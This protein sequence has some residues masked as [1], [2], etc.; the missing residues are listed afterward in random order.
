MYI[1]MGWGFA[2]GFGLGTYKSP[3]DIK[4]N[5]V[6]GIVGVTLT[7][8]WVLNN[9]VTPVIKTAAADLWTMTKAFGSTTT[10]AI[11]TGYVAG[12]AVGTL[13]VTAVWGW[14]PEGETMGGKDV[15]SLYTFGMTG[16]VEHKPTASKLKTAAQYGW[17]TPLNHFYW[18]GLPNPF[19]TAEPMEEGWFKAI[20]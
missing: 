1:S 5:I 8:P 10:G 9:F 7:R 20:F 13:A 15:L 4:G 11:T 3:T 6:N 17:D 2:V 12:A 16:D 14:D 18:W 19:G